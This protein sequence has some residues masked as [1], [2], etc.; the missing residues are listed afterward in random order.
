MGVRGMTPTFFFGIFFPSKRYYCPVLNCFLLASVT[1]SIAQ[2]VGLHFCYL[3]ND[4]KAQPQNCHVQLS[5]QFS[6]KKNFQFCLD[7]DG[8]LSSAENRCHLLEKQLDYMR[9]MVAT[10]ER[11]RTEAVKRAAHIQQQR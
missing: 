7:I 3:L 8:Q 1:S 11:D 9:H 4:L 2:P 6:H 5:I 10:A